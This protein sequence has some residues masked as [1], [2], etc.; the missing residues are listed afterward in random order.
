MIALML[1]SAV[2]AVAAAWEPTTT[3]TAN[4]WAFAGCVATTT[5]RRTEKGGWPYE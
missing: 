2:I 1:A 5:L 4:P 3:I